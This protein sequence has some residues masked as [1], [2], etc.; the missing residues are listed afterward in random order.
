MKAFQG[1]DD[2]LPSTLRVVCLWMASGCESQYLPSNL[3]M[4]FTDILKTPSTQCD[5]HD[6]PILK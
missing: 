6:S 4:L 5:S 2:S 1:L 3:R